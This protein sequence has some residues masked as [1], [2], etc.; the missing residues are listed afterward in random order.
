MHCFVYP[1]IRRW[2][3]PERHKTIEAA[4]ALPNLTVFVCLFVSGIVNFQRPVQQL[5]LPR[6]ASSHIILSNSHR[7]IHSKVVVYFQFCQDRC[8]RV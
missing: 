7:L 6:F 5:P 1:H 2:A 3:S 4:A 8:T